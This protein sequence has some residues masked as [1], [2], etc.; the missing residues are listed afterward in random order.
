MVPQVLKNRISQIFRSE[1]CS[2]ALQEVTCACCAESCLKSEC[3]W[4]STTSLNLHC[5]RQPD[6]PPNGVDEHNDEPNSPVEE[7]EQA[8]DDV[9]DRLS[10]TVPNVIPPP[11]P[12]TAGVLKDVLVDPAGCNSKTENT[13]SCTGQPYFPRTDA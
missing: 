3:E 5:L 4:I 1:T 9:C 7:S 6:H 12:Y 2:E 13:C 10:W 11:L 8:P